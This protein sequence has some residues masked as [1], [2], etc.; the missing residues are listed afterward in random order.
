M[1]ETTTPAGGC[2]GWEVR[3]HYALALAL[4]IPGTP[5]MVLDDGTALGG[6]LPPEA[7]LAELERQA[8]AP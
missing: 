8:A 2:G 7:L 6:Y 4:E 5:M 3:A 1:T